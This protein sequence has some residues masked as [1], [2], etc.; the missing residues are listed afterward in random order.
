MEYDPSPPKLGCNAIGEFSLLDGVRDP[1]LAGSLVD[2]LQGD[3][4]PLPELAGDV[5]LLL[6]L[7]SPF[8]AVVFLFSWK[9]LSSV[10][11]VRL[12]L[13]LVGVVLPSLGEKFDDDL[14]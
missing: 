4:E 12:L 10:A 9:T 1:T 8:S 2:L 6:L 11:V 3:A 13:W 7:P 14:S 5:S